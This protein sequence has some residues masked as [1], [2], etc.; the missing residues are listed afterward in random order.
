MRQIKVAVATASK[1]NWIKYRSQESK[2]SLS[3][4]RMELARTPEAPAGAPDCG[5]E[6]IA[7]LDPDGHLNPDAWR[8]QRAECTVRRFWQGTDDEHGQLIHT[9]QRRW[10]FSYAPGEDDDEPIWRL[11][12]HRFV[13]GEYVSVT[14]H[15][16]VTRPF[17][18]VRVRPW[19]A[20]FG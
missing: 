7:P 17:R 16:G 19:P 9:R 13:E 8:A 5:Y 4:V 11:D 3:R 1:N 14:E 18:V 15:D 12:T 2:M 20:A 6:L 10:A